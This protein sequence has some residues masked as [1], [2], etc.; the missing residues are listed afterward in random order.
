MVGA[1]GKSRY[2]RPRRRVDVRGDAP[3]RP[4]R[5]NDP[6]RPDSLPRRQGCWP[7]RPRPSGGSSG[8][9]GA[10]DRTMT[11]IAARRLQ[12]QRLTG[13]PFTSTVDA[14]AWL[15]AV[16][17]QDYAGAKWALGQRTRDTT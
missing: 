2:R 15:G 6:A 11:D 7:G 8:R 9:A 1:R 10:G 4:S 3:A 5:P 16:Q 17:S 14:V 12:T 13:E